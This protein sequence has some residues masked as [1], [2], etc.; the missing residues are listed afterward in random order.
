MQRI[1]RESG[2]W[3]CNDWSEENVI[4]LI[5]RPLEDANAQFPA[6]EVPSDDQDQGD[7]VGAAAARRALLAALQQ[8]SG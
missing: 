2:T 8:Q 6:W 1:N 7:W 4:D 3:S 5:L